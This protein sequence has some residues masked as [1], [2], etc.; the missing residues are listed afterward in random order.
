MKFTPVDIA[1]LIIAPLR[2]YFKTYTFPQ[3]FVWNEDPNL[4]TV[5]IAEVNDFHKITLNERPRILVDRGSYQINKTGLSDNLAWGARMKDTQGLQKKVNFLLY[6]G[7]AT[8]T[9]EARQEGVCD[10]LADLCT[11]F[12]AW[13]RPMICDT[14]NFKE[15]GLPMSVSNCAPTGPE[16]DEKF[17]VVVNLPYIKEEEWIVRDDGIILKNI[18]ANISVDG[19]NVSR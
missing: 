13:T 1:H 6:T 14:Q 19:S 3:N 5:E 11:H 15:F 18:L 12:I 16:D 4:R 17:Q 8:I 10:L 2:Y 7:M 9:I